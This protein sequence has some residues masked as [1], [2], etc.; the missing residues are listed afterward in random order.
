MARKAL[1]DKL[2]KDILYSIF[3]LYKNI[4]S[5]KM[6]II[7]NNYFLSTFLILTSI[8]LSYNFIVPE[9]CGVYH[10]DAIYVITAKSISEGNG[11]H[12]INLPDSPRQTK[13]PFLYPLFLSVIWKLWPKFPQNIFFMKIATCIIGSLS[14]GF[15]YFYLVRF[16]NC[17]KFMAFFSC[18][19][20][21]TTPIF[22]YFSTNTLSE[23]PFLFLIVL[24]LFVMEYFAEKGWIKRWQMVLLGILISLPFLCRSIGFVL[25]ISGSLYL[26]RQ[27]TFS[28][29]W[30]LVGFAIVI[31]PWLFW[32][33]G[34]VGNTNNDSIRGYY[35]DYISWLIEF[36]LSS[37]PNIIT[38]NSIL[39]FMCSATY[40][41]AGV[42]QLLKNHSNFIING[43]WVFLGAIPWVAIFIPRK[44]P[45]DLKIFLSLYF[46]IICVWPWPPGRFLIPILPFIIVYFFK[47]LGFVLRKFLSYNSVKLIQISIFSSLIILNLFQISD[48]IK[49]Q[50]DTHYPY[51]D[52]SNNVKWEGFERI[53]YWIKQNT[54]QN[55]IVAYGLDTMNYLYT[56]RSGIRPFLGRPTSLFYGEKYPAT[57]TIEDLCS[58]LECYR[59]TY[60]VESPMPGFSEEKPF[61]KLIND[62]SKI[63][64]N[65]I[66]PVYVDEDNRF[67][68]YK[69]NY[70]LAEPFLR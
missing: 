59:P 5:T 42:F 9:V 67:K 19:L 3:R 35:T 48:A 66:I 53:F 56:G 54:M 28:K 18:A 47:V 51:G 61:N 57:G 68:I 26:W 40:P 8:I 62:F 4:L 1:G 60:L 32:A 25:I 36:G 30:C 46:L 34:K 50:A 64:Q 12:L 2:L 22:L 44:N 14:L 55:D 45:N 16:R 58:I 24:T 70:E 41:A 27:K 63:Y 43:F 7:S 69:I 33:F 11:Y 10:D 17:P 21:M 6:K 15:C 13:Y 38:I 37:T 65:C 31:I 49:S 52:S 29:K 23:I 20:C 39:A